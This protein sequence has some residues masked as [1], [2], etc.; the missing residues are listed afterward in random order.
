[1]KRR[2]ALVAGASGL[3]GRRVVERLLDLGSWDVIGLA[4]KP[5]PRDGVRSLPIDLTDAD[6]CRRGLADTHV[7]HL[8]YTAR[9]DHP[10]GT[11]ESADINAAMLANVV[12]AVAAAGLEHVHAVHGSKYYGH[13]LGPVELPMCEHNARA[14]GSNFYF[15]QEDYLR[16]RSA[17]EGWTYT[18]TRPHTF[19]D[20]AADMPRSIGLLI[21]V[22]AAVQRELGLPLYFP[23]TARAYDART[24]FTE[25][26]LLARAIAWMAGEPACANE[27]FNVVNGDHPRWSELWPEF[28][29]A[30]EVEPAGARPVDLGRYMADKGDVWREVVRRHRLRATDLHELVLWPYGNYVFKPE[31]DIMSS[32]QKLRARGFGDAVDTRAMFARHFERYRAERIIPHRGEAP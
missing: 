8:F 27:A 11:A 20:A 1:M 32:T 5:I 26:A 4:R 22:Y 3:I 29:R 19:C 30:L 9:Y 7:S 18:T 28:A 17:A 21:A 16:R 31:W 14:P 13:Q 25:V 2:V 23:G 10:E 12:D 24:Q 6:D 15:G